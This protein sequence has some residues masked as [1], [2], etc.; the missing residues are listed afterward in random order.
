MLILPILQAYGHKEEKDV[1]F[2]DIPKAAQ[3]TISDLTHGANV[4][5][6]EKETRN[7]ETLYEAKVKAADDR[8]TE[9]KVN[10]TGDLRELK[11]EKDFF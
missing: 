10:E 1:S 4:K 3:K 8:E 6:V 2:S 9:I 5:E 11:T 7:G